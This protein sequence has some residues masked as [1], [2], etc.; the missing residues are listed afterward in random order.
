MI[1]K[2]MMAEGSRALTIRRNLENSQKSLT[3]DQFLDAL[4]ISFIAKGVDIEMLLKQKVK[5]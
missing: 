2:D 1:T 5:V 4:T 3:N